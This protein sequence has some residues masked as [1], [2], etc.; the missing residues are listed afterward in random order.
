M[1]AIMGYFL[2]N[3]IPFPGLESRAI[4]T[5]L[6]AGERTHPSIEQQNAV[7]ASVSWEWME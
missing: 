4:E 7:G 6:C 2:I 1:E 3:S 5:T